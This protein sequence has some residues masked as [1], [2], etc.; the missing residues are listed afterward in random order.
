MSNWIRVC[1]TEDIPLLEGRRTRINGFYVGVFRTEEGFYAIS[2]VC[3][4]LGGPLSDGI[5]AGT[6]VSCPLHNRRVALKT[7]RMG[8]GPSCVLT[9]PVEIRDGEVY[10]NT[11]VLAKEGDAVSS[12]AVA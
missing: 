6:E 11:G 2:D 3:P 4:H 9:F 12:E 8:D 10:L 1:A 7:G 5:V